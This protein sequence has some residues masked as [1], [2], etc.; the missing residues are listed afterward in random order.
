MRCQVKVTAA[1]PRL[2][3]P[4]LALP[5]SHLHWVKQILVFGVCV[6]RANHIIVDL[7][8]HPIPECS[9]YKML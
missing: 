8:R 4:L 6:N 1:E 5:P 7:Q 2:L 9:G 3:A